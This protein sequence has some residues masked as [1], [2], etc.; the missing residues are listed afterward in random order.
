MVEIALWT[1][2]ELLLVG[3]AIAILIVCG[4][5]Y[6]SKGKQRENSNEKIY[7]YGFASYFI[8]IAFW[9]F[10][11]YLSFIF[12]PGTF[13]NDAL[14]VD[15]SL[16]NESV[17]RVVFIKLC[18]TS[19]MIGIT[20]YIY[21]F[22]LNVKLTKHVITIIFVGLIIVMNVLPSVLAQ[23]IHLFVVAFSGLMII[24]TLVIITRLSQVEFKAISSVLIFGFLL[25]ICGMDLA[26]VLN[27]N[28]VPLFYILGALICL[29]PTFVDPKHFSQSSIYWILIGI[30]TIGLICVNIFIYMISHI[31]HILN[32][33]IIVP[34]LSTAISVLISISSFYSSIRLKKPHQRP[35]KKKDFPNLLEMFAKPQTITEKE[36]T[37]HKEQKICMVCK[38]KVARFNVFICPECDVLYCS[39]CANALSNLENAYWVCNTAFDESKPCKPYQKEE[40]EKIDLEITEETPQ[41]ITEETSKIHEDSYKFPKKSENKEIHKKTQKQNF[42]D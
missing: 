22:E 15:L 35:E 21:A 25:I 13:K 32:I 41:K 28:I 36:V 37:F 9:L 6:V 31:S 29:L 4:S 34:L 17:M 42:N 40:E 23:N 38:G 10:F 18:W 14:Y 20:L 3:I 11:G 26:D 16:I 27:K 39:K 19:G 7:M 2:F 30:L 12:I 5:K 33:L 24:I 8:G 1:P